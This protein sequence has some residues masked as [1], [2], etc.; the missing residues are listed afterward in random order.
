MLAVT[1]N[2]IIPEEELKIVYIRSSGPG[3]QN[4]NK[5]STAAQLRFDVNTSVALDDVV[6]ERLLRLAGKKVSRQ[7]IITITARKYR[8]QSRNR[9]AAI[10][11]LADMIHAAA[12]LPKKRKKTRPGKQATEHRLRQKKRRGELKRARQDRG[13]HD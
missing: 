11:R 12:T 2:I 6:R 7:G 13:W 4:V 8:S 9:Q 3:G 10:A 5:V 1:E